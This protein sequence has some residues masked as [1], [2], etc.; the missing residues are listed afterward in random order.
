MTA[1]GL[2]MATTAAVLAVEVVTFMMGAVTTHL[3][4]GG[5]TLIS[6]LGAVVLVRVAKGI[7]A[8]GLQEPAPAMDDD[9]E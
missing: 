6:V 8:A 1:T 4:P 3:V 2:V 9:D 5:F 7:A